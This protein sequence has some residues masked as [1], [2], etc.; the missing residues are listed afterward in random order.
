MPSTKNPIS[1]SKLKG[2][3]VV[4]VVRPFKAAA[5]FEKQKEL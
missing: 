4:V 2:V 5:T 3:V 1:K